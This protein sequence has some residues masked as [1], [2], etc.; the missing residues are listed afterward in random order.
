M[1]IA[2]D[3]QWQEKNDD[4]YKHYI[5]NIEKLND[6]YKNDLNIS[7]IY[8]RNM[9]TGYKDSPIDCGPDKFL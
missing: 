6:R 5:K 8:D 3:R 4:E 9:L 7:I 1:I 2:F